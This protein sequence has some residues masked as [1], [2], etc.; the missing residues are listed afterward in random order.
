MCDFIITPLMAAMGAGGAGLTG[1]AVTAAGAKAMAQVGTA[2]SIA[3]SVAQG[4]MG[5]QAANAQA[6]HLQN[7]SEQTKALASIQEQRERRVMAS[8]IAQQRA[9]LAGRGINLSSPTAVYLGQT[10][11]REMSFQ[12][13]SIRSQGQARAQE[14]SAQARMARARA[15]Q[16]LLQ[17]G[18]SAA[19]SFLTAAPDIWP[20]LLQ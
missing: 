10:A 2:V 13:Q 5:M 17:G 19:G 6:A 16:S 3:G 9:E 11:A 8:Q 14:L 18:L 1:G 4:V 20:G 12:S 15:T 7:A